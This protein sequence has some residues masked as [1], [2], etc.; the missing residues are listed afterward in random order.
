[1]KNGSKN[2]NLKEKLKQA[3]NSTAKVISDDLEI[4]HDSENS[5]S[6]K[7]FD[8]F[9]LENLDT[10]SDFIKA[11]AESDSSALK[12]KFSN[13]TIYQKNLPSNSSCKSL[14]SI[15]EKIR[16][17]LLGAKM[18]RGIEKN[19]KENYD[20]II[21]LKRKD[22][23]KTKEDVPVTEAFELY[24]LK[25]FHGIKLNSLTDNMLYFWEKDF[26]QAIEKHIQYLKE[27]LEFQN[28][29]SSKFS[30]ILQEMEIFQGEDKDEAREENQEN[31]QNNPSNDD[32]ESDSED[33]KD[34]NKEE[35]TEASL[36]S[37]YD[38]DEYKLDEQLVET[39]SD[40]QNNEQIIQKK[41]I[42][43][44]NIDYKIFTNQFDEI[45]KA[46]NLENFDESTKLRKTLDQ[47]LIGFQDLIT[48][49][50]NKLQRQLLAKQNRAWEFDLEEGLLD[51][52]KLPRIIMDPYNS[53][54]FKKEKDLDFKDTVVTLLIDNSGSMR[55]RPITIA[56]ICADI[57]SRT[58]ERCSVKVE[59]LGFTT[60]N[61][62]GGKSREFWNKNGKPKSP[63]RLNDLRHIIY[64]SADTHW[65][66][67][68]NNL[69]LML[70]EGL[71]KENIDGEAIS[72]AYSRIKKRKEERK[73]LMVISDGA[74][75]DDSTLSV[76][77]GDFLEK[78]LKKMVKF[79]EDK[80]TT[81]ILAIGIGHDVSRYYNRAIKITDVNE[82]GDVM[83]SQLSELFKN[84]KDLH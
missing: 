13:N 61:W 28:K 53:L 57:L 37:D 18:L 10:K 54:S 31:G 39:D 47:Q 56:A 29:Y 35:E 15:A 60:K 1:M 81:E 51:S 65:R 12:K 43:D 70:K 58:L 71:L 77:S 38:I 74:P 41:N 20:Q 30:E 45:T 17:E 67:C 16:Y 44:V 36:D 83:I 22:Q 72:W 63:G 40:H 46:E 66:Q 80:S 27:N 34:Q 49:L 3:L 48:K 42:N 5:K 59:I 4:E 79:I 68:K 9:D 73:I 64:K 2:D 69:G 55:G 23:L 24:M 14:Y 76:N 11:R 82:L 8:F 52:S 50:A 78:H 7:K 6:S 19:F 62:K 84:K 32:Q 21:K 75:V 33:K 26:D 25:K